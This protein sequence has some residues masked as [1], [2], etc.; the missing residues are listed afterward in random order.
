[1]PVASESM[2]PVLVAREVGGDRASH[3]LSVEA[4]QLQSEGIACVGDLR[5][6][7]VSLI[8]LTPLYRCAF[9]R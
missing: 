7:R 9:S 4:G 2:C 8:R 1:M 3:L 5:G 6:A